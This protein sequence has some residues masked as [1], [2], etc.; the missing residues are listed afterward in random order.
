[1]SGGK[2]MNEFLFG[3][4]LFWFFTVF[5]FFLQILCT[6]NAFLFYLLPP[7]KL[8]ISSNVKIMNK[9]DGDNFQLQLLHRV[10]RIP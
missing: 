7:S 9:K 2:T 3:L 8:N 5:F 6:G 10:M 4:V 1:M